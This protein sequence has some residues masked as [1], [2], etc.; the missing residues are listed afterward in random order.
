MRTADTL[1]IKIYADGAEKTG[2]LELSGKPYIKGFTTN[3][4]LMRK[5][6]IGDYKAFAKEML[7]YI[8]DKPISFEVFSDEWDEMERQAKEISSWGKNVYVKIPV[9][10]TKG[11]SAAPLVKRLAAAGIK[12]NVTALL[13][14]DQVKEIAEV[15]DPKVPSIVSVFAG[16]IADSGRDPVE[17]TREA[18]T[19]LAPNTNAELLWASTREV[20]NIV[21]AEDGG[22]QIITVPNDILKK[23]DKLGGDVAPIS[24]EM[25][26][27]FYED[28]RAA[29]YML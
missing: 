5:A 14:T 10:N 26:K 22:C 12:L 4:T 17:T 27:M 23:I 6:G 18:H 13:T 19:I 9:T 20:F 11:E 1:Q 21:Q 2:M 25:V 16:R 29:G 28:G 24:L 15:L 7:S 3:P 8:T